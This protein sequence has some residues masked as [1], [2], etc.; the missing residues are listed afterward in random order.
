MTI[1]RAMAR[2]FAMDDRA[3][4]RHASPWSVWTRVATL[5]LIAAAL[6]SRAWLG[7]WAILPIAAVA[8][9]TW[10]NPRAFPPPRSLDSW[11][12]RGVLGER[13]WLDRDRSPVPPRHRLAPRILAAV[14]AVGAAILAWGLYATEPWPTFAGLAVTMLAKLW[15]LDRM[16]WLYEDVNGAATPRRGATD[17]DDDDADDFD[18]AGAAGAGPAGGGR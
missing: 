2:A 8:A 12:S 4:A 11:A 1:E 7:A 18:R 15:F 9:W 17:D 13:I 14:A 5:P 16:A 10:I 3:W 6:W